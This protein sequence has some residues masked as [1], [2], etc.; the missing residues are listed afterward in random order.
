MQPRAFWV[1][2]A[3]GFGTACMWASWTVASRFGVQ[4]TLTPGDITLLRFAV[5]GTLML[6]LLLK[7]GFG[8]LSPVQIALMAV[9]AGASFSY[10]GIHGLRTTPTAEAAVLMNGCLPLITAGIAAIG[11]GE[12]LGWAKWAGMALILA[13]V[14]MMEAG[15]VSAAAGLNVG[16]GH[17]LI[18]LATLILA[19]YMVAMR[20]WQ[21]PAMT[22]LVVVPVGSLVWFLPLWAL[23]LD[24]RLAEAPWREI[25]F[26]AAFQGIGP[27]LLGLW[28]FTKASTVL[29]ASGAAACMAATPAIAALMGLVLLD[30]DPGVAGWGGIA[31]VSAGIL[32]ATGIMGARGRAGA[33]PRIRT[34]PD[35]NRVTPNT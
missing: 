18:L 12:R 13:G 6:P 10:L 2:I 31:V 7:R 19:V 33:S 21:V 9:T 28:M 24:S 25:A 29:G 35:Q 20:I 26:Q 32:V 1:G 23:Q 5:A 16:T 27:S 34:A 30:E 22:A 3:C 4:Q 17:L 15:S 11:F 14:A 8:G